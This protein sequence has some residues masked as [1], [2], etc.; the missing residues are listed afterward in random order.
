MRI[1]VY[2]KDNMSYGFSPNLW[3]GDCYPVEVPDDFSGGN[4]VCD[5]VTHEWT[6]LPPYVMTHEDYVRDAESERQRLLEMVSGVI[7]DWVVDLLLNDISDDD[8]VKLE[9]WRTY[10]KTLRRLDTSTAPNIEWPTPPEFK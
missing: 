9:A 5:P 1:Y 2:K 4:K 7:N 6:T 3:G 10:G 8:R